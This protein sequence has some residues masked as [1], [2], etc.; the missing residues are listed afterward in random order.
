MINRCNLAQA[1]VLF[2]GVNKQIFAELLCIVFPDIFMGGKQ[3]I[4]LLQ[5]LKR[6]SLKYKV[7]RLNLHALTTNPHTGGSLYDLSN[8]NY[9]PIMTS[10]VMKSNSFACNS[11]IFSGQ[12]CGSFQLQ[13]LQAGERWLK[14]NALD[15]E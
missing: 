14:T 11:I 13:C 12:K 4:L 6:N 1:N 8:S 10:Q 15:I 9:S 7:V 3:A 5:I 2:R